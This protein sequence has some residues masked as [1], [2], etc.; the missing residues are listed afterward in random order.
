M[1]CALVVITVF[2]CMTV[3]SGDSNESSQALSL[4]VSPLLAAILAVFVV[5]GAVCFSMARGAIDLDPSSSDDG[6]DVLLGFEPEPEADAEALPLQTFNGVKLYVFLAACSEHALQLQ[7]S[8][9]SEVADQAVH[10]YQVVMDCFNGTEENGMGQ[11]S[12]HIAMFVYD[13]LQNVD[14]TF[15]VDWML[16]DDNETHNGEAKLLLGLL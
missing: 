5:L 4:Y 3:A 12:I 6:S 8:D 2:S 13:C 10:L 16:H 7:S 15:T 9:N 11:N 1:R 14:P